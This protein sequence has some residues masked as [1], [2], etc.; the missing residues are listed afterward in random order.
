MILKPSHRLRRRL[1][2]SFVSQ[3]RGDR[4]CLMCRNGRREKSIKWFREEINK[5]LQEAALECCKRRF[6][7][8]GIGKMETQDSFD[9][10]LLVINGEILTPAITPS[11]LSFVPRKLQQQ[12][13]VSLG[14]IFPYSLSTLHSLFE[15]FSCPLIYIFIFLIRNLNSFIDR[16]RFFLFISFFC[17]LLRSSLMNCLILCQLK[18]Y[19]MMGRRCWNSSINRF[20][21]GNLFLTIA[22]LNIALT[23]FNFTLPPYR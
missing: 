11:V 12:R 4:R 2:S 10:V 22:I 20:H 3:V 23:H 15:P 6:G 5:L 7:L 14:L 9:F 8:H 13:T 1:R 21:P 18:L 17:S 19:I 16:L